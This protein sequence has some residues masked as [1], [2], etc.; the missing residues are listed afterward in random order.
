MVHMLV[1][2]PFRL[3]D[4]LNFVSDLLP[5]ACVGVVAKVVKAQKSVGETGHDF[6][7]MIETTAAVHPG[8]SGGAILNSDGH[9]IS[10]VTR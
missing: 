4:Y 1:F 5:S 8:G 10:L 7:A 3:S 6:P 9:M 2:P